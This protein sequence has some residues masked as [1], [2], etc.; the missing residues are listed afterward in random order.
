L[1]FLNAH[2]SH[3]HS[4]HNLRLTHHLISAYKGSLYFRLGATAHSI[5]SVL[6]IAILF[7]HP[8]CFYFSLNILTVDTFLVVL[9]S[10]PIHNVFL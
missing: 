2:V 10:D 1:L 6:A 5:F 8:W 9:I 4:L 7:D 3:Q